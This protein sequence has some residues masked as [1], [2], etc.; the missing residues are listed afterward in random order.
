MTAKT[1]AY[2][3]ATGLLVFAILSGGL[4]ELF[5]VPGNVAGIVLLGYPT[6]F[7]A[8]IGL[9]K[10]L[11]SIA[12]LAPRFPRLK[13]W[14]YAGIFFNVTGAAAS[15]TIVGDYG[16]YAFHVIVNL[17]LAGLVIA[18]WT[19]RPPSRML[20]ELFP[21]GARRQPHTSIA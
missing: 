19:L 2:W 7:I 16:A 10:V 6:Y 20:G 14:A 12:I 8:L 1:S 18:S 13:E 17:V 11:G 5:Q 3:I 4:A 15:H 21:A 9:W